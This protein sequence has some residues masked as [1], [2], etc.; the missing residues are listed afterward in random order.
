MSS[1]FGALAVALAVSICGAAVAQ[2]QNEI[3]GAWHGT[4]TSRNNAASTV[5]LTVRKGPDGALEAGFSQPFSGLTAEVPVSNISV[6]DGT[7][8]FSIAR[9]NAAFEGKWNAGARRWE[10]V[11][12][13]GSIEMPLSLEAGKLPPRAVVA[14]MDGVWQGSIER[15]GGRLRLVLRIATGGFGTVVA[16][17]SP[18]QLSYGQEIPVLGRDGDRVRVGDPGTQLS[19][20]AMLSN[21]RSS[22]SGVWKHPGLP[23]AQV[24]FTRAA[25]PVGRFG[26]DRPQTPKP[27][28]DYHVED[29]NFG[30]P[31]EQGVSLAGTLT[32]PKGKG[33]FPAA[34]L[35]V[36]SGG[37]DRDDTNLGHKTFAV[38]AD[39]LTRHGVAVLRYDSRGF[40]GSKGDMASAS[41]ADLA[42]DAN[43]AAR[44][45]MSRPEI[46]KDAIG[47][48]G[49]SEGGV[50]APVAMA[51]N[52]RIA[53]LVMLAGPGEPWT[54]M[55]LSQRR[56]MR[57][58]QGK[59]Q[60]ELD[61][62]EPLVAA[63]YRAVAN[64]GSEEAGIKAL[65]PLLTPDTMA[66]LG[67][68]GQDRDVVARQMNGPWTRYLFRYDPAVNLRKIRV[69][70][71]VMIGS[72]DMQAPPDENLPVLKAAL[73]GSRDV[74]IKEIPNLNHLFQTAKT[75]AP[76]EY[77]DIRETFA[78]IALDIMTDWLTKRFV[79]TQDGR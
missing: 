23:D 74:T 65:R 48:V 77:A 6:K 78:P 68:A 62:T 49:H 67:D 50:T 9:A 36:G 17:D 18:D 34:I 5:L 13:R 29:V 24:T 15:N 53:F 47:F 19:Y 3:L 76:G 70:V 31:F 46:R 28:F 26:T 63:A 21:D 42:T 66:A 79:K 41:T 33:P 73:T 55:L 44:Y 22:M 38:I 75:G 1:L 54:K 16:L 4:L 58:S 7:L 60:Q 69:P 51:S 57:L 12:K 35:I 52:P 37:N 11:L 20:D 14:E 25:G 30:N 59:S 27:P 72:L 64:A 8:D 10:G 32:L 45:L 2:T 56:L 61:R 43:S 39:H 40:G 71:L